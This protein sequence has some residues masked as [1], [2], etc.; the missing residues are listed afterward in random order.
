M[1]LL[2]ITKRYRK[3]YEN[4][5]SVMWAIYRNKSRIK[6]KLRNGLQL[7]GSPHWARHISMLVYLG[8]DV[9]QVSDEFIKF[10]LDDRSVVLYG[11]LR[12]DIRLY[13]Y[14]WLEVKG[15]RVLDVGTSIGDTVV[16]FALRGARQVV[17]FEPYPFPYGYALKNLEANGLKNV[18]VINAGVSGHD[19]TVKVTKGETTIGSD[20]NASDE[21]NAVEVPIYSLDRVLEEYG[22][23]DVIKMDCEGC[24]YDAIAS[25]K[26]IGEINQI[27]IEYH[28]GPERLLEAL[29]N[30][31][32]EVKTTKPRKQ[33]NQ[34]A[35]DPDMSIGY[36]YAWKG[37]VPQASP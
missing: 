25:S 34:Y 33:H 16:Y 1:G 5:I 35:S 27:Q 30:A 10:V 36:L 31:G 13:D 8:G 22:P 21:P 14:Y 3:A 17:A 12:G 20:L 18:K 6:L 23:F 28:Y 19:G 37:L 32:F 29:K 15:K 2:K 9:R 4:W 24:E 7:E 11:W 26:R